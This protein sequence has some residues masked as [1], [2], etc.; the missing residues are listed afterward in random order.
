MARA[1]NSLARPTKSSMPCAPNLGVM[2]DD[3][4]KVLMAQLP[5][6]MQLTVLARTWGAIE[7]MME[8]QTLDEKIKE[9]IARVQ[10]ARKAAG[11]R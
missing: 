8:P 10:A 1:G 4:I 5:L 11:G 9:H 3:D 2:D 7:K 6:R